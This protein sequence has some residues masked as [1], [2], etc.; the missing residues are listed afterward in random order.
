MSRRAEAIETTRQRIVEA[1]V[2]LHGTVGPAATTVMGIAEEAGVTRATVYR[3][4]PDEASLFQACSSHWL[5]GQVPPHPAMW[6]EH[7]DPLERLEVGLGD[8]Y[9]FFRAGE[10]MLR[11]VYRDKESLPEEHRKG[12]DARDAAMRDLLL[13]AFPERQRIRPPLQAA[14]GHAVSFWTWRSLCV[15]H[16]LTDREAVELMVGLAGAA[17][18]DSRG[19]PDARLTP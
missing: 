7:D 15:D 11:R 4:F 14:V 8:L 3:H 1:A 19:A 9:R 10:S 18:T 5:A 16:G 13:S 17:V 2:A 12:L 6:A